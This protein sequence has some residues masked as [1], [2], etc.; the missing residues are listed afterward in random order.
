MNTEDLIRSTLA[1]QAD[2]APPPGPTLAAL[3][4][5]KRRRWPLLALVAVGTAA[6]AVAVALTVPTPLRQADVQP[7]ATGQVAPARPIGFK[8]EWL[9]DGFVE[10]AR[11]V[12]SDGISS[13]TWVNGTAEVHFTL[14]PFALTKGRGFELDYTASAS[15]VKVGAARAYFTG[16][17]PVGGVELVW[18]GD[19]EWI[20]RLVITEGADLPG[21]A[22][23]IAGSVHPDES[24]RV[25][26][27]V[28]PPPSY[29]QMYQTI[30]VRGESPQRWSTDVSGT[31]GT[32]DLRSIYRIGLSTSRP[33]LPTGTPVAVL[34]REGT[35]VP[36]TD[37]GESKVVVEV[38]GN[39]YLTVAMAGDT[40]A[41]D[42][43]DFAEH[44]TIGPIPDLSWI[45]SR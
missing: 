11:V 13:R 39:Q 20:M 28:Q 5:P 18:A 6:V 44:T 35:Y 19:P 42:L 33:S 27:A 7:A 22:L 45:G 38:A 16:A 14:E 15:R 10:A 34:G 37:L 17:A 24:G 43:V 40:K 3:R 25:Q 2:L 21:T 4:R 29:R 31:V 23:R 36:S 1:R 8:P 9:P 12:H 26:P 30:T 32:G 41:A